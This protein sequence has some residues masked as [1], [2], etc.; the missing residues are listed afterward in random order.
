MRGDDGVHEVIVLGAGFAG[1]AA[2]EALAGRGVDALVLEV[3][4]AG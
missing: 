4:R 3:E 1:L 2:A